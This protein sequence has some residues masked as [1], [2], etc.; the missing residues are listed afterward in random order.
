MES[1]AGTDRGELIVGPWSSGGES[2]HTPVLRQHND[3]QLLQH[4][5]P[6]L[7]RRGQIL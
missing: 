3:V 4:L 7:I 6:L 2:I 5:G 1:A